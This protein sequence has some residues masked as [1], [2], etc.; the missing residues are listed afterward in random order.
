MG[1]LLGVGSFADPGL[2]AERVTIRLGP[3]QQSVAIAD[4]ESFAET[5]NIS[6]A[7]SPYRGLLSQDIRRA[8]QSQLEL[9]PNVSD[10]LIADL[11]DSAAGERLLEM[12]Q[13]IIPDSDI[14]A[15]EAALT[16]AAQEVD[17]LSLLTFLRAY[18]EETITIDGS[19]MIALASQINLPYWQGQALSSILEQELT[20]ETT[21]PFQAEFDPS[22]LGHHWVRQQT[23]TLQDYER[24]RTIPVDLYWSRRSQGPLIVLSHGFGADRR[25]LTYLAY[26]LAS[27]GFTVAALEHP[28][29]N[30]AWLTE[31]TLGASEQGILGDILPASEFIDR[32]RDVTFLLDRLERVNRYSLLLQG[33]FNTEQVVVI[34]HSLGG[35]TALALAGADLN[36]SG[37]KQRCADLGAAANLS[38]AD[39]LQCT[40]AELPDERINLRDRRVARIIALNPVIGHMFDE[41]SLQKIEVP[42]L[43]TSGTDD[44]IT[45]AV[46]QQLLPFTKL[47][48]PKYLLTAIGATHL[49]V[50]DPVNLNHALT[51]SMF[52]RERRGEETEPLRQLLQGVSLAFIKQL[53]PEAELYQPFLT[54]AYA[55]SMSTP[56]LPLRLNSELTPNL[57]NWLK[58]LALPL[59]RLVLSTLQRPRQTDSVDGLISRI[60][61][62]LPLVMFILPGNLPIIG[63]RLFRRKQ[64][65]SRHQ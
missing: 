29:S 34:G 35:Y 56:S 49:S 11:L 9:D 28:A 44:T 46:S 64:S 22:Q 41:E 5:G 38:P 45:P 8:L 39:W 31:I 3:I 24:D 55:Q 37:L 57:M 13:I 15:L 51:Q 1:L 33:K 20:V 54:A 23:M 10:K 52:I 59:E 50:G 60:V 65:D 48:A 61:T 27:Y 58:M 63:N 14:E 32:P 62:H 43:M 53:T 19:S 18:P 7:L 17:G 21:T 2:A 12:L 26:H 47:R 36:P 30:V 4:L 16:V 6:P 40:A 42:V 25:F